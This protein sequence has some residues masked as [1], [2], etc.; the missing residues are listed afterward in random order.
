MEALSKC[1]K[2]NTK[3][4]PWLTKTTSWE[5]ARNKGYKLL[6]INCFTFLLETEKSDN[7]WF[8]RLANHKRKNK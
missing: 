1:D 5:I 6:C 2:C 7:I 8:L 3:Y 4:I